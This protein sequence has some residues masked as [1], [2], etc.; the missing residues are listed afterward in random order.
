MNDTPPRIEAK[1][2]KMLLARSGA[3][4]VKMGCSMH[5]AARA[6]VRASLLQKNGSMSAAALRKSLF[7]RFYG[8]DFPASRRKRILLALKKE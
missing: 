5:G 6:L 4:R 3:E 7:L 2:R 8:Q 1:F